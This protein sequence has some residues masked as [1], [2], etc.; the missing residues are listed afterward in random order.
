MK[1]FVWCKLKCHKYLSSFSNVSSVREANFILLKCPFIP[2]G[3][4]WKL[5]IEVPT[6]ILTQQMYEHHSNILQRMVIYSLAS[7]HNTHC[8][9]L[10]GSRERFRLYLPEL[11]FLSLWKTN[12]PK[13]S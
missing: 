3:K 13:H 11:A 1:A 10:H 2:V 7:M 12:S 4:K 6:Y 9:H 8:I 5:G